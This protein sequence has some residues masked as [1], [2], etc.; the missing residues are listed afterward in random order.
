M[1]EYNI[2]IK[3]EKVKTYRV[4][5]FFIVALNV[6]FF[7]SSA[8][9]SGQRKS[10][11][12]SLGFILIYIL[13]R[14]YKSKKDKHTFF[15]DEWIY[16]LLMILWVNNYLIAIICLIL[17]LTYTIS[18]QKIIYTFDTSLI[19]Q[20]NFPWKKYQW[21]ELSNVILKDNMLTIDLKNNKIIQAEIM[22]NDLNEK[23]FNAFA[24]SQLVH[25]QSAND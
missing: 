11:L 19:K 18:L 6:L 9:D 7:I 3:N 1:Q 25:Q 13:Y 23:E 12:I 15:F 20:K 21:S 16:F 14:F 4:L 24:Q 17:F 2:E 8:F 22:S 10:S 5:T